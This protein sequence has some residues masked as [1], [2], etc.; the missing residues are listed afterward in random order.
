V[1]NEV[2]AVVDI[3]KGELGLR[4]GPEDEEEDSPNREISTL[5]VDSRVS[6]GK[7]EDVLRFLGL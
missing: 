2:A 5:N 6:G 3:G 1:E 7:G 4:I